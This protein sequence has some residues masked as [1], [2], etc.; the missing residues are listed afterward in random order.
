MSV[1]FLSAASC[2]RDDVALH[3]L[4]GRF[5][6]ADSRAWAIEHRGAAGR[7]LVAT[8]ALEA[9]VAVFTE[10]PLVVA[11]PCSSAALALEILAV[12]EQAPAGSER[13]RALHLLQAHG[14]GDFFA[15]SMRSAE[16]SL[17]DGAPADA[18]AAAL[19][20]R[21]V[22]HINTHAAGEK[23]LGT[24]RA[25]L[26]LLSSMMQHECL[27]SCVVRVGES[28]EIG[29]S[30]ISLHTVR[31]VGAGE[32]LSIS[33]CASYQP[34]ERR[35][36]L[37]LK[38]HGF[39]CDCARCT[40]Q[41]ELVR[42]L[43]CPACGD[44][45]CSPTLGAPSCRELVCDDCEATMELDDDAWAS[46]EAAEASSSVD[47]CMSVCHPF[48]HR[49]V[50][51]YS[52]NLPKLPAAARAQVLLQFASARARLLGDSHP[53]VAR[54]LES[55]ALALHAAGEREQSLATFGDAAERFCSC[56][57]PG[58]DDAARCR[59]HLLPERQ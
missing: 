17:P 44:G 9:G 27:A 36:E 18:R 16:S 47:E 40:S 29:G 49:M 34:R 6:V 51:M 33:Y 55:A 7:C 11:S 14:S 23:S 35:R 31:A 43:Q 59:A 13:V 20:A 24:E 53:L 58:C 3:Q 32:A 54:D 50:S 2:F 25:V 10:R 41:P 45:P 42:A 46:L 39:V 56:F 22:A 8:R 37:L 52:N 48:H 30:P 28:G 57:G 19:W 38:Q 15:L 5:I 26:G 21:G 12:V 1:S 4:I